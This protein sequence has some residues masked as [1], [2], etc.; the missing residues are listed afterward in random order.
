MCVHLAGTI[1]LC[2][3]ALGFLTI[4]RASSAIVLRSIGFMVAIRAHM[5]NYM[6]FILYIR[7]N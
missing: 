6:P 5:D 2:I 7:L 3:Y 1:Y 4:E